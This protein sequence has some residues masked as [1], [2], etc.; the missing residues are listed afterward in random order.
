[1]AAPLSDTFEGINETALARA[2]LVHGHAPVRDGFA[3]EALLL[4][5]LMGRAC[6]ASLHLP[7][8]LDAFLQIVS[9]I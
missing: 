2:R 5:Q 4:V 3:V 7:P 1:M 6:A 9:H 8:L